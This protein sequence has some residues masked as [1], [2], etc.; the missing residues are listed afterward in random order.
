MWRFLDKLIP[1]PR[2]KF[3]N[4]AQLNRTDLSSGKEKGKEEKTGRTNIHEH[5][6][7]LLN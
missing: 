5:N 2:N 3:P 6:L 1:T 4:A 7:W